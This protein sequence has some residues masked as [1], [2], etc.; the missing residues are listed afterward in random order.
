M[1]SYA[2]LLEVFKREKD[3]AF[4]KS[5]GIFWDSVSFRVSPLNPLMTYFYDWAVR[6]GFVA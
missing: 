3:S 6:F 1:G 4:G 5:G 2:D